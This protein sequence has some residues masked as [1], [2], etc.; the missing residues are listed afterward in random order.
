MAT[1]NSNLIFRAVYNISTGRILAFL[2]VNCSILASILKLHILPLVMH[3]L[4]ERFQYMM[5]PLTV[6]QILEFE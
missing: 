5:H 2:F 6:A 1:L 3:V 4:M